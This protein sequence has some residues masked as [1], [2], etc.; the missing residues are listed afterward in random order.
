VRRKK[1][2]AAKPRP[3]QPRPDDPV[4]IAKRKEL[5][6]RHD[7]ITFAT[8]HLRLLRFAILAVGFASI[9]A[10]IAAAEEVFY[11]HKKSGDWTS[12][13]R[14]TLSDATKIVSTVLTAALLGLIARKAQL[15]FHLLQLHNALVPGQTFWDTRVARG[16]LVELALH[17]VHCPAGVYGSL[18]TTSPMQLQVIYDWDSLLSVAMLLRLSSV[19]SIVL[20]E[21][22]GFE[23]AAARIVQRSMNLSFDAHFALRH[24]LASRP[25]VSSTLIYVA[26]V[27]AGT[28]AVRVFE[29]PVCYQA[30]S[31]AA[32]GCTWK[33]IDSP[34]NAFWL[35]FITSLTVG[36]GDLYPVTHAGRVVCITIAVIG[37][38][39][40]A[41]L[42]NGVSTLTK[43]N[44]DEERARSQLA[45]RTLR[46]AR[47][48]HAG[49]LIKAALLFRRDRQRGGGAAG[50]GAA[51]GAPAGAAVAPAGGGAAR[52]APPSRAAMARLNRALYVWNAHEAEWFDTFRAG[53]AADEVK[54]D[55]DAMKDS[56]KALHS[57]IDALTRALAPTATSD[58]PP[59]VDAAIAADPSAR[60]LARREVGTFV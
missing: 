16:M 6:A 4:T 8:N 54:A 48:R 37:I 56:L 25:I 26:T 27:C 9:V 59:P 29:R 57:K 35:A 2:K 28:Y 46:T 18:R 51:A 39:V 5:E 58:L 23:T 53:D 50:A 33:D 32:A 30:A 31:S 36:Y 55:V 44:A 19:V 45:T 52:L 40:I 49:L 43:F 17:A 22:T 12:S 3:P 24:L 41:L 13:G 1:N 60:L 42:V 34:Y 20:K 14:S 21:M 10:A 7:A 11:V 47:V 38:C 15:R